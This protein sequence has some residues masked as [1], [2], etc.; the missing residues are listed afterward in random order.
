MLLVLSHGSLPGG[1][2]N[3]PIAQSRSRHGLGYLS[4]GF[5]KPFPRPDPQ[6]RNRR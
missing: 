2:D 3:T 5:A 1:D 6:H 4:A